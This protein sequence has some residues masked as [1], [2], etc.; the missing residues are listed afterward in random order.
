MAVLLLH[1]A[2]ALEPTTPITVHRDVS[3][4]ETAPLGAAAHIPG[5]AVLTELTNKA[6]AWIDIRWW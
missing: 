5:A 3:A 6:W 2:C 4:T 1:T